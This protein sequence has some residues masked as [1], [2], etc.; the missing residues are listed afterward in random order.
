MLL[1]V[2]KKIR[3]MNDT[4][5]SMLCG[6][7]GLNDAAGALNQAGAAGVPSAPSV[8]SAPAGQGVTTVKVTAAPSAMY[9]INS[10]APAG[11]QNQV[12]A[13][14]P[15]GGHQK[16]ATWHNLPIVNDVNF[17]TEK[18]F[19]HVF[20][21]NNLVYCLFIARTNA[22]IYNNVL[23]YGIMEESFY[24]IYQITDYQNKQ[25]TQLQPISG[26][27]LAAMLGV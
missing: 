18:S 5:F 4:E 12:V 9:P 24:T 25:K 2:L 1:E 3:Y 26:K 8:P 21:Y 19:A 17:E 13:Q 6:L 7:L 11:V 16:K 23:K 27:D 20:Q 15:A 14:N 10:A 22:R